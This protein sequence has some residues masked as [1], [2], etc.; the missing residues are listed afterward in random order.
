MMITPRARRLPGPDRLGSARRRSP[1]Q[2][3]VTATI[4]QRYM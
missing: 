1:G 3:D 2:I 4:N